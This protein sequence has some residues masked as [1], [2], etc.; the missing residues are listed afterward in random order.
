MAKRCAYTPNHHTKGFIRCHPHPVGVKEA[1]EQRALS[2][3]SGAHE[4]AEGVTPPVGACVQ[5]TLVAS[6]YDALQGVKI[7]CRRYRLV[8][9]HSVCKAA[10]TC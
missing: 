10:A 3:S 1:V 2:S 6:G 5:D 7:W 4:V 8:Y 9:V